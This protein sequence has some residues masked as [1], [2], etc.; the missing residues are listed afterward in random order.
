MTDRLE[1]KASL[2]VD[3]T[4]TVTGLAWPFG[5]GP[6]G[7]GD[8]ITKGAFNIAVDDVPMLFGHDPEDVIGLWD[9]VTE[10]DQGLQVRGQLFI[11]EHRR[12][13]AVRSLITSGLI[14]GLS[15]G[16]RTKAFVPRHGKGRV[17]SALDLHEVSIVR[18]PAHP[19][20]RILSAKSATAAI[21]IAEAINRAA[22]AFSRK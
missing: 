15:I 19:R 18:N 3:E 17:I 11:K 20:A 21:S 1:I 6:D 22:T 9:E 12:A 8:V 16:F 13:R 7:Y 10:T 5:E 4:G 2:A 14:G